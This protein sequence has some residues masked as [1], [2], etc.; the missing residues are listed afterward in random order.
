[1]RLIFQDSVVGYLHVMTFRV[2]SGWRKDMD[3]SNRPHYFQ[4]ECLWVL[5]IYLHGF[6]SNLFYFHLTSFVFNIP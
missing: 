6:A 1:M 5:F 4:H 2:S 3:H